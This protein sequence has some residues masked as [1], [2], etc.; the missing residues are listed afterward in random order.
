MTQRTLDGQSYPL[1]P[2]N[3]GLPILGET[4]SFLQDRNFANKRHKKY[5]SVFKTHLFGRPT[6][7]LMG[8][9]ANR[10]IL[11]THFDHFSWREG[12]PKMF[13]ELLGRS[14]FLQDGEEHRRNRKLLMPAFHGPA[15]NQYI[16]TMEE[17]IDRYLNNWEKQGSIA[18][19]FELKKMTFE[20]ASILL[21][22]SEPGELTDMLS[23]WFTELTSGLFTL[24]IALP[25][26]TYSK[27]LKARD[28][29]LNHIEKVVQERQ[30]HPTS[31]ALGL[32]VQTR[33][34][35]GNS[36]SLEELKV[37]ALLMLFA[38]HE[39]TTSMLASFNMVLAQ[40]RQIRARL[41]TEIENISPKG[42]ITLEQ[43][44]QMTYL[45]QVLKEVE[46]F[47]PPVAGG[48]RGVVKPCVFGGYYIPEGWQ[49]LYRI[50][51]THLDQ[52]VY[53]NPEQFDPDRFSPE[54]AENK[55]MEYSL[56]GFGG[57][58]RICLGYTFAQMEMKIFAV[59]LLRHYDWELLPDQDLS[60][61]PISTINSG[62]GLLVK[63]YRYN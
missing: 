62:S 44:R 32:L 30:K 50:D 49:L 35:E 15:L 40:N 21:I 42:S 56:V 63:F 23:Q 33:D 11:S 28:R 26:T 60:F 55:K 47:Y 1:P 41:N 22:G 19:F 2:G 45:D 10:F 58:S 36:L 34:E 24:P 8:P 7:I 27:A 38:G 31:D 9:E 51:A 20:I 12:W 16:T 46:R 29:L 4:L 61:H 52:R 5:G 13:R 53:T 37:Q 43:L 6:V 57:G 17:I 3:L 48:F 39:T 18:W 14:L 25:G 54:R 59:H